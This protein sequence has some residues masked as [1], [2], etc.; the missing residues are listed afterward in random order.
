MGD[1]YELF[2]DD[3]KV[4]ANALGLT[5]TARDRERKIPMA[6]VPVRAADAYLSRLLAQGYKVAIC[7]Q[8]T[9]PGP[10]KK[11]LDRGVVR[12]LTP[13][14][15][16]EDEGL[17]PRAS[18]FLLAVRPPSKRGAR[19]RYGLAW[20]DL[21]TGRFL[22]ADVDAPDLESEVA[23]IGP[24]EL[25]LPE[26]A[27][28]TETAALL[29]DVATAAVTFVPPW[30]VEVEGAKRT[31]EEHFRVASLRAFGLD[32][33]PP[34]LAAAGAALEYLRTTQLTSLDHVT[35]VE[36]HDVAGTLVLGPTTRRRLDLVERSDGSRDATLLATL[37]RTNTAMGARMLREWILAPLTEREAIE[38][39]LEGVEEFVKDGFL[40]KDLRGAFTSVRDIE[41]ILAR[42]RTN[43]ANARDLQAL[44]RS[45][46]ALPRRTRPCWTARTPA[47]SSP[48]ATAS[49]PTRNWPA[50]SRGRSSTSP[51]PRSP[52]AE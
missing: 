39:R 19:R 36:R 22:V 49:T 11:I 50:G 46:E 33:K 32:R 51:P 5:L 40:R 25:L 8:L 37:D 16:T 24:A 15:I 41:R 48:C 6:G 18:N 42:V 27:H 20:V 10:G 35:R 14:T 30:T 45:L 7:E 26:D 1:F 4:A 52:T 9:E 2:H 29:Q 21:S 28:G 47:R 23:R 3:A 17:E 12:V 31:L 44:G 43:R 38:R 13:G 34:C